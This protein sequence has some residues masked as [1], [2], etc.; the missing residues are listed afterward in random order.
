MVCS[1]CGANLAD[2]TQFCTVCG[3]SLEAR[4]APAVQTN[5]YAPVVKSSGVSVLGIILMIIG[6]IVGVYWITYIV[7]GLATYG[8]YSVDF[9]SIASPLLN[10]IAL[11]LGLVGIGAVLNKLAKK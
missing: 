9:W 6:A 11:G 3:N 1:K 7:Y 2:G 10:G 5:Y 4:P 8:T